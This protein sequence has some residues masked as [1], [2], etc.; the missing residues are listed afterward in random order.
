[1]IPNAASER[2]PAFP[3]LLAAILSA[4]LLAP[5]VVVFD[6]IGVPGMV[7]LGF[8]A[9]TALVV[10]L[11]AGA[12]GGTMRLPQFLTGGRSFGAFALGLAFGAM[13]P[14]AVTPSQ[15]L[16]AA[17]ALAL[18]LL[19]GAPAFM[20]SG[21]VSVP[22]FLAAR[23]GGRSLRLLSAMLVAGAA[24]VLGAGQLARAA[25]ALAAAVPLGP[26][27][28]L[29]LSALV[30]VAVL[31]PAGTRGLARAALVAGCLMALA[32]LVAIGL[33]LALPGATGVPRVGQ[34]AS[35]S[36]AGVIAVC[37]AVFGLPF[38][39]PLATAAGQASVTREAAAWAVLVAV[40]A[41]V[42]VLPWPGAPP[43]FAGAATAV[44]GVLAP[45]ATATGLLATAGVGLG[46]DLP[47]E[48]DRTRVSTS[49]RF[50][51]VRLAMLAVSLGAAVLVTRQA[52]PLA[53]TWSGFAEAALVAGV[54][55]PLLLTLL[56]PAAGAGAGATAL[57][58][59]LAG[60]ALAYDPRVWPGGSA[61]VSFALAGLAAGLLG[62]LAVSFV[63]PPARPAP[64]RGDAAL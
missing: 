49:R 8:V 4:G 6:R 27:A 13:M 21:A 57:L 18:V 22:T 19:V 9:G 28:T 3:L 52:G 60:A 41:A 10:T 26:T 12:S 62:G 14:G 2:S 42:A 44:I 17:A 30:A 56:R 54:L 46:Y 5:L 53:E 36:A 35:G 7:L 50:A 63:A 37:A 1:M 16:P 51:N 39:V 31:V 25:T 45:L 20:R 34:L 59:G 29:A 48:R 47:G 15:A 32:A 23:Y 11:A 61:P 43:V 55:P 38:H 40:L 24:F 33:H 58:L 64:P